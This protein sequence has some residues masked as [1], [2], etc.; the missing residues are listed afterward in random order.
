M[1][2]PFVL[3]HFFIFHFFT[4]LICIH[5]VNFSSVSIFFHLKKKTKMTQQKIF[6]E[7]QGPYLVA[8]C[9]TCLLFSLCL[10]FTA[11]KV[12]QTYIYRIALAKLRCLQARFD[13]R[14]MFAAS[15]Y[16]GLCYELLKLEPNYLI[17]RFPSGQTNKA[18]IHTPSMCEHWCV[19]LPKNRSLY[20]IHRLTVRSCCVPFFSATLSPSFSD[21]P[22]TAG[23]QDVRRFFLHFEPLWALFT[24]YLRCFLVEVC[25]S[26]RFRT[27][28]ENRQ[29]A[30]A[31]QRW[32]ASLW[33]SA[34]L[35][36]I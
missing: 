7:A 31:G 35:I 3:A 30:V 1:Q 23:S 21:S 17:L 4:R 32:Q 13:R 29:A 5:F 6:R 9:V 14:V 22:R 11:V 33:W 20:N 19:Y 10:W 28:P 36:I 26:F 2:T 16:Y 34:T 24:I 18:A 27:T 15:I 12:I 25:C 8:P